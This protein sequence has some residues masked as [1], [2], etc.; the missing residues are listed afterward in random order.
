M[1]FRATFIVICFSV[2]AIFISSCAS[3][4]PVYQKAGPPAGKAVIYVYRPSRFFLCVR[5]Y[6]LWDVTEAIAKKKVNIVY[7]QGKDYPRIDE[8]KE[9]LKYGKHL[10]RIVNGSYYA[11]TVNPGVYYFLVEET[12]SGGQWGIS[13]ADLVT[14]VD[15][16]AGKR[17]FFVS[18]PTFKAA[19]PYLEFRTVEQGEEEIV[20]CQMAPEDK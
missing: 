19:A 7:D 6:S 17:Y 3:L 2:C 16:K 12:H 10:A 20:G 9:G 8:F 5:Y 11:Y 1:K 4:G 18:F 13:G 15:A 14:R